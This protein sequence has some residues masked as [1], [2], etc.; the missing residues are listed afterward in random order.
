MKQVSIHSIWLYVFFGAITFLPGQALTASRRKGSPF[1]TKRLLDFRLF[2]VSV[3]TSILDSELS[4]DPKRRSLLKD[5]HGRRRKGS[6]RSP[7]IRNRSVP[8]FRKAKQLERVGNWNRA[9]GVYR[10][11]LEQ[12]PADSHTHL[13]LARLEARREQSDRWKSNSEQ[14][15]RKGSKAREAFEEGLRHCPGSVQLWQAWAMFE[16]SKS[17]TQKA[18]ELFETALEIEPLNPFVCHAYGLMEKK[19][20]NE[21]VRAPFPLTPHL[22][23]C[24]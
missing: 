4:N 7:G 11:I 3:P 21:K 10:S 20:G 18:R 23:V 24:H 15:Q 22:A 16:E 17:D 8:L 2:S 6:K 1:L 5:R 9:V 13:A 19:L 14:Y 12:D